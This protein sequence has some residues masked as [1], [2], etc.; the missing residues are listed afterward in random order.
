M[1][2]LFILVL[3]QWILQD[4][5]DTILVDGHSRTYLLDLP[6]KIEDSPPLLIVLHGAF[7]SGKQA[8]NGY[9]LSGQALKKGYVVVYPDGILPDRGLKIRTWNAGGCCG[10]AAKS[11]IDDVKFLSLL[12]DQMIRKYSVAPNR[13]FVTG[14]SNG[15]MMAYRLA[16]EVPDKI[17]AIAPVSGYVLPVNPC[18]D[19]TPI[20]HFHSLQD[21]HV[22]HAG[23]KGVGPSGFIFPSLEEVIS[24]WETLNGS[25]ARD[26]TINQDHWVVGWEKGNVPMAYYL[27]GD[28]GHSWPG[29]GYQPRRRAD[30]PSEAIDANDLMLNFFDQIGN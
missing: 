8:K 26:T 15:A 19:A 3:S 27:T 12:I 6:D 30:P 20:I 22:P 1:I 13:V 21:E 18:S 14:M 25:I 16:C 29:S 17:S 28:G 2:T 23:G 4:P 11:E 10:Y 5:Q 7:G 9:G 24:T